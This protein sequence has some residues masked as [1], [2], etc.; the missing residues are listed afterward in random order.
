VIVAIP[1][2]TVGTP[3]GLGAPESIMTLP[4]API[5]ATPVIEDETVAVRCP[6]PVMVATPVIL[7][8][9]CFSMMPVL[10]IDP[11]PTIDDV[12]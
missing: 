3:G 4:V 5:V 6:V 9:T 7:A 2:I 8:S 10:V 1:V 11:T 12:A